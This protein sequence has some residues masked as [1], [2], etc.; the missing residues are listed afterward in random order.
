MKKWVVAAKKADFNKIAEKYGITPML[1]RIM[2]NRDITEDEDIKRFLTGT[3]DDLYS[4]FLLDGMEEAVKQIIYARDNSLKIRIVG[5]YDIDGVCASY[6]LQNGLH[7]V[8]ID[9]T[10]R[11]PDRMTDGY[12]I[13]ENII[14]EAIDD[15]I[16]MIVTCDNGIAAAREIDYAKEN[17]LKVVITDHHEI[18][19]EMEGDEKR[20]I[21]PRADAVVD[22]KLPGSS[23]PYKEI[24]GA[25]VAYK[26]IAALYDYLK[27][28]DVADADSC[29]N[30]YLQFAAFATVGDVMPLLS[31]N[32]LIVKYGLKA[33]GETGNIGLKALIDVTGVDRY[34]LTPFHVGFILGPCINATGRLDSAVRALD[35]FNATDRKSAVILANELKDLNDSR[36][37][38]TE[39]YTA[40]AV[41]MAEERT[42]KKVLVLFL[43]DCHESLA[44]IVAGRVRERF[45]KPTFVLTR[46]EDGVKG[47]GRSIDAYHMYEEMTK[48]KD[49]F[50]KYGGHKL[51]AGLSMSED[52]VT[53]LERRLNELS[54]LNDDDLIEK[55]VIDIPMPMNYATF[56]FIRELDMLS[57]Y[58]QGNPHPLFAQKN[59]CVKSIN[60][61]GK[62]RNVVKLRLKSPEDSIVYDGIMFGDGDTIEADISGKDN[63]SVIYYPQINEYMGNMSVQMV[64]KEYM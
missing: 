49:I 24:C 3:L 61:V 4:P 43:P 10:V 26:L 40:K 1:A 50:T 8:G 35:L 22:P 60:V 37:D 25:V 59:L 45:Y 29:L 46:S 16:K 9:A 13:N 58:G 6:I 32:H 15:G 34:N 57:P 11:L 30:E 21:I 41:A 2:R 47:S 56:D 5:D 33:M 48:V 20:Y 14:Q 63:I 17:G 12:G 44:G 28:S 52:K 51:A 19:Y 27:D 36:K 42:D 62:N 64:V 7:N 53:E 31:E 23:Y 54:N 38:M 39:F 55:I 18:P